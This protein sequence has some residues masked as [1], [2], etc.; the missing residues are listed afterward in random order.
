[1]TTSTTPARVLDEAKTQAFLGRAVQDCA[2]AWSAP[3]VLIGD[4]R[5]LYKAMAFAGPLTAAEVAERAHLSERYVHEWLLNQVASEYVEYDPATGRYTLPDEHAV[6]LTDGASP[7]YVGGLYYI[8]E[9]M[10]KAAERIE[11]AFGTGDGLAWGAQADELFPATDRLFRPGYAANLVQSWIPA[12]DG[13]EAKL[14]RGATV[15]DVG[16]GYGT[17]TILMARAYPNSTFLGIDPHGPSIEAARQAAREAGVDGRITFAV[18][19]AQDFPGKDYDLVTFFD[20]LHD[21]GDP[22]GALRHTAAVLA[23]DGTALIVEPMAGETIEESANPVS[24]LYSAGSVF[25]CTPNAM[26]SGTT[27]LGNQ[28]PERRWRQL[29]A[30]EGLTRFRRA[31]ETPFNRIFEARH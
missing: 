3:L 12:L 25:L 7:Y 23:P 24:R 13:V 15:V 11:A 30:A 21:M 2:A 6:P 4:R 14:R 19:S 17:S 26:A 1:M 18:G 31:A 16:C 20:C 9:A 28:V 8:Q 5:G 22:E 27:A 29:A 10:T